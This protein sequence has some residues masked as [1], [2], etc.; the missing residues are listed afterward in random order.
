MPIAR[1]TRYLD[2]N[3]VQYQKLSHSPAF[4]AQ[5]VAAKAHVSGWEVAKTVIVKLDGMFAMA[6]LPAS[7]QIDFEFFE[8]VTGALDIQLATED[9]F[10][11]MFPECDLG[12]MPPFGNLF[13]MK[14]YVAPELAEDEQIAFSAGS[15]TEMIRLAYDDFERL[16]EP[17][18]LP[19][20]VLV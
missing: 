12:A 2:R 6:V 11:D 19:F 18:M 1:L 10:I 13:N 4:S 16:V 9:E 17:E 3:H 5:D 15:H 8:D 7:E 20:A 14:V